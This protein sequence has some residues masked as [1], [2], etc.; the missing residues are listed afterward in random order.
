[1]AIKS[2]EEDTTSVKKTF[3]KGDKN[4]GRVSENFHILDC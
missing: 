2:N 1:M 3:L 4:S